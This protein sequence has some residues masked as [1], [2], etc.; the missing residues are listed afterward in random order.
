M[1]PLRR[2]R[3]RPFR[4]GIIV[5]SGSNRGPFVHDAAGSA[6]VQTLECER[7]SGW[8]MFCRPRGHVHRCLSCGRRRTGLIVP[9]ATA[10]MSGSASVQALSAD[11]GLVG[12]FSADREDLCTRV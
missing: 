12:V 8:C 2:W 9:G 1:T 3:G 10:T 5:M 4:F 6:S 7:R 11:D